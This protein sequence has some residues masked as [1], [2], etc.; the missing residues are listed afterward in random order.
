[1]VKPDAKRFW[2]RIAAGRALLSLTV[3]AALGFAGAASAVAAQ[4]EKPVPAAV[5]RDLPKGKQTTLSLYVT[6]AQAYEMW[7]AAPDRIKVIDVRTPEE[8]ALIGHPEK[9]LIEEGTSSPPTQ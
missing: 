6:A 9:I 8:F 2:N 3:L 7:K 5:S 1:M 4:T